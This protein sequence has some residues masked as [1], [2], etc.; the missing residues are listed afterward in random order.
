MRFS[1]NGADVIPSGCAPDG[2]CMMATKYSGLEGTVSS[3]H[4][5]LGNY[6]DKSITMP[7]VVS[8]RNAWI[9]IPG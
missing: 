7:T 3:N 6:R 1:R 4:F 9:G 5:K 8:Y 2:R